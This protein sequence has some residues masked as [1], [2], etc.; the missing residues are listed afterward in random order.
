MLIRQVG[1][2]IVTFAGGVLLART[3]APAQFG[4]FGIVNVLV[5]IVALFGDVGLAPALI[6]RKTELSERDLQVGFTLQQIA[7]TVVVVLLW[8]A[9]PLIT[10]HYPKAPEGM[11][12]LIRALASSLYLTS[13]RAMSALQLE[14]RLTYN[15]LAWIE[16]I[17]A[18]SYQIT[19][20]GLALLGAG[21]WSLV[22]AV[23]LRGVLGTGLVFAAAPWRIRLGYDGSIARQMLRYGIPYQL[24]NVVVHAGDWMI[25]VLVGGALG[26]QAVG[27]VI[28]ASSNGKKPL[29]L[30][31]NVMRVAFTHF[32]RIQD[33][34]AEIERIVVRY[35]TYL[36]LPAGLWCALLCTAGHALVGWVYAAR[37]LP[38][39]DALCVYAVAVCFEVAAWV[40]GVSLNGLGIVGHTGRVI[41]ARTVISMLVSVPLVFAFGFVGVPLGYLVAFAVTT[42][43]MCLGLGSGAARR[44]WAAIRWILAP[45]LAAALAGA[46]LARI[47][48]SYGGLALSVSTLVILVYAVVTW[49]SAP[50]WLVA[51]LRRQLAVRRGWPRLLSLGAPE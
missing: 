24:Q 33:D 23:L 6:Q 28:W 12:W 20:V 8:F 25:P 32:S 41:L 7:T 1:L 44:L 11:T 18:L 39:V 40:V 48:F 36:L 21:T 5:G 45:L 3:L 13:W 49:L 17:E 46:L 35:L 47:P 10:S 9:A 29:V 51:K 19:A 27:F 22:W 37:W 14:R 50:D 34:R 4:L 43:A 2:Q 31:D 30:V 16:V 26:P 15:A 42:P 38:G